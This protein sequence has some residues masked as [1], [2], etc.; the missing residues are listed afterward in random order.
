MATSPRNELVIES[1]VVFGRFPGGWV[2]AER[3]PDGSTEIDSGDRFFGG[4]D[5]SVTDFLDDR[6]IRP[7]EPV[8][9]ADAHYSELIQSG[10]DEWHIRK[11]KYGAPDPIQA[12]N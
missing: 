2:W 1:L 3:T 9:A 7:Y 6:C 8:D 5:E 4:L 12:V 10:D 11:Y